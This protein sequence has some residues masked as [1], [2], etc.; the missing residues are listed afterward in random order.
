MFLVSL[1]QAWV[2]ESQAGQIDQCTGTS[3]QQVKFKS[4]GQTSQEYL[5]ILLTR[6]SVGLGFLVVGAGRSQP[7]QGTHSRGDSLG[8]GWISDK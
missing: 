7:W 2:L 1:A 8:G 6:A 4:Q 3:L 5:R